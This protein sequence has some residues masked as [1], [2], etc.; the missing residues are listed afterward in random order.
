VIRRLLV[1][2]RGEIARRIIR[3]CRE[4]EI[5]TVAVYSDADVNAPHVAEADRAVR[6]GRAPARDSYLNIDAIITAAQST[7]ADA[8]HPGYGFLSERA[9]FARACE[10]A[11]LVFVGPPASALEKMGSK[12]GARALMA[13]AGVPVVPGATPTDQSDGALTAAA[14]RVGF[15]VLIKPAA[16]GGGIGMKAVREPAALGDA[17][18]AARREAH[19]S[20]GNDAL[21]IERL[22]EQPRHVEIQVFADTHGHTVHI[23]ERECSAQR[24]HQKVIEESPCPALTAAVRERMGAAAI[25]AARAVGYRNAGTCEFLLE[26]SSDAANFYFLEMNTRLQVEHPVTECVTGVDLVQAQLHVAS[27]EPLPFTQAGL[28]QRGHAIECRIYAEDPAQGFIPQ[29]GAILLYREPQGPGIRV[30]SGVKAGS[31]VS[32][33]YDPML[34]KLVVHASTREEARRRAIAALRDYAI[35]GIRTNIPFLLQIL[36]H[37]AFANA[38]IDTGFLDRESAALAASIPTELPPAVL[39]AIEQHRTRLGTLGTLNTLGTLGTD[40][41]LTLKG[42]RG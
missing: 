26:G 40:P 20:F 39:A 5:E 14:A 34:A 13:G 2:N 36:Q 8:V 9:P 32:V 15:P 1:A 21:Y 10:N 35:L 29:A 7:K 38:S 41:F 25:A 4:L 42:W 12:T 33:H 28:S 3:A 31:E 6:I 24:R 16:G 30:D 19:A 27:G 18:A 37:Q 23:F 11:G 17:L 22:I